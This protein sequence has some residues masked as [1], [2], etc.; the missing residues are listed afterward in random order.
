M[1]DNVEFIILFLVAAPLWL[2]IGFLLE[3]ILG[4]WAFDIWI[5]I[6]ILFPFIV[7]IILDYT[8]D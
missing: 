6:T 7:E 5:C 4:K 2:F 1:S 8:E 3:T